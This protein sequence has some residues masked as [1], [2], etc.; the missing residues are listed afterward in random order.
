MTIVKAKQKPFSAA[1]L[2]QSSA[3]LTILQIILASC[4]MG[5]CAQIKIPLFFTPVPLTVQTSGVMLIAIF[6]GRRKAMYAMMCYLMQGCIGLPVWAGG[7]AG[8]MHFMGPTGGYLMAYIAQA[9]FIGWFFERQEKASLLQIVGVFTLSVCL[10][11]GI[12]SL[13]LARFV[14][15]QQCFALGFFPFIS[16]EIARAVLIAVCIRSGRNKNKK[17]MNLRFGRESS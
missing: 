10:Q 4:F 8:F 13:W 9:C 16:S 11:L 5:I 3:L 14:G 6:L 2:F 17:W 7:A 15:I 12:G 1:A